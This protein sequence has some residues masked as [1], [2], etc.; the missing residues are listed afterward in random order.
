MGTKTLSQLVGGNVHVLGPDLDFPKDK[1]NGDNIY[2]SVGGIDA[3]GG[4]TTILS[5]TGRFLVLNLVLNDILASNI[6]T[7]KLT[8]DGVVVWN[9]DPLT[10]STTEAYIGRA[11]FNADATFEPVGCE[12]SFLFQVQMD[13]D[14][15]I[16]VLYLVRPLQ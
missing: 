4:L 1:V 16:S 3:T 2:L 10:N 5:L 11:I 8:V 14:T 9:V 15:D 6:A 13:S 12:S 7:V